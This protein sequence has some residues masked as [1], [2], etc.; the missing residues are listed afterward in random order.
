[1]AWICGKGKRRYDTQTCEQVKGV[2]RFLRQKGY[3]GP[4]TV[5]GKDSIDGKWG[6]QTEDE[7]LWWARCREFKRLKASNLETASIRRDAAAKVAKIYFAAARRFAI[8]EGARVAGHLWFFTDILKPPSLAEL[9]RKAWEGVTT[10]F[11]VKA[12]GIPAIEIADILYHSIKHHRAT[13]KWGIKGIG[14]GTGVMITHLV[15]SHIATWLQE[16][17]LRDLYKIAGNY[18]QMAV[19]SRWAHEMAKAYDRIIK[20]ECPSEDVGKQ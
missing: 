11:R 5:S 1:M 18:V 12:A 16:D 6:D 17:R 13:G 4:Y 15:L 10:W 7:Y 19:E 9:E 14:R 2:Q 20:E 8:A 3:L